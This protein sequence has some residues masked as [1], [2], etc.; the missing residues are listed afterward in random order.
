MRRA[1]SPLAA[2]TNDQFARAGFVDRASPSRRSAPLP[3]IFTPTRPKQNAKLF[4]GRADQLQRIISGIEDLHAH[5]M[6][7]GERGSGKTSLAN[8]VSDK[9]AA[10][11]YLVLRFVCSTE[12]S[13]DDIFSSFLH[14]I[15]TGLATRGRSASISRKPEQPDARTWRSQELLQLF[16]ISPRG[17]SS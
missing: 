13:F 3:E 1:N 15:P 17:I 9:A 14:R 8:V 6:I 16:E 4:S 12:V 10:A 5:I 11:G 7:Y 2:G